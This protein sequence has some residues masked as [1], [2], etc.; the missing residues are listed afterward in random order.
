[1]SKVTLSGTLS[2]NGFYLA[3]LP[4]LEVDP[5]TLSLNVGANV[6]GATCRYNVQSYTADI[7]SYVPKFNTI[8]LNM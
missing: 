7:S 3:L 5:I 6:L 4:K 8:N 1:M 2:Y